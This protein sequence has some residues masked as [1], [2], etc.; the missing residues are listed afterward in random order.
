[1][2]VDDR[3][4]YDHRHKQE[5][6]RKLIPQDALILVPAYFDLQYFDTECFQTEDVE[7]SPTLRLDCVF[8]NWKDGKWVHGS[9]IE[10]DRIKKFTQA[11]LD[12]LNSL[13]STP[14]ESSSAF[15]PAR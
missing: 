9:D 1:V 3:L 7:V 5:L 13:E 8:V 4:F 2:P 10:T 14:N 12:A 15:T 11:I 6:A